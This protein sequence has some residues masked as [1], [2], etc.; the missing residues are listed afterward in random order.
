MSV[1]LILAAV[2]PPVPV[3]PAPRVPLD[4]EVRCS[5]VGPEVPA[6]EI[7]GRVTKLNRY[8]STA[9]F[10][11]TVPGL[12]IEKATAFGGDQ[13]AGFVLKRSNGSLE[14]TYFVDKLASSDSGNGTIRVTARNGMGQS[15]VVATGICDVRTKA[16]NI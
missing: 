12:A 2:V 16:A 8:R 3:P 1:L 5:L 11:S 10:H 14:Y 4:Y 15:K 9:N 7:S 13:P 6:Q